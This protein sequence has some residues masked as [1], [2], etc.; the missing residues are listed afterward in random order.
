MQLRSYHNTVEDLP[1]LVKLSTVLSK[2]KGVRL[3][4][5]VRNLKHKTILLLIYSWGCGLER[6]SASDPRAL[7]L[8][9]NS[10]K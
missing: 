7:T 9:G 10:F 4:N 5:E 2:A 3:F 8:N 1:C 6:S